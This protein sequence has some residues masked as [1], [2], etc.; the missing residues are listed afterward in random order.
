MRAL[1]G[2]TYTAQ[3]HVGT[4]LHILLRSRCTR[5]RPVC[6]FVLLYSCLLPRGLIHIVNNRSQALSLQAKNRQRHALPPT[7]RRV[8][9]TRSSGN[10]HHLVDGP[11]EV[12]PTF[13]NQSSCDSCYFSFC[14]FSEDFLHHDIANPKCWW[15]ELKN[16]TGSR[17]QSFA[18]ALF[19]PSAS[20]P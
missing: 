6:N 13:I 3:C 2:C 14:K 7:T 17:T 10:T 15:Q 8:I 4:F 18:G 12:T 20:L 16:A 1:H 9:R 19:Q 11:I 5:P